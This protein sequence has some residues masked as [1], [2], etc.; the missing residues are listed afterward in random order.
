MHTC[1]ASWYKDT[2][3]Q[4]LQPQKAAL[5][6]PSEHQEQRPWKGWRRG[7]LLTA[8]SPP[9]STHSSALVPLAE[10]KAVTHSQHGGPCLP[11]L[12][13]RAGCSQHAN[14]FQSSYEQERAVICRGGNSLF[15]QGETKNSPHQQVLFYFKRAGC[16]EYLQQS[17]GRRMNGELSMDKV[18]KGVQC[19]HLS[20]AHL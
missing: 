8:P 11:L 17:S 14:H 4:L 12:Q 5:P 6:L 7:A 18:E 3:S 9:L 19:R 1:K 20:C 13:V 16:L 2:F 15:L 10:A